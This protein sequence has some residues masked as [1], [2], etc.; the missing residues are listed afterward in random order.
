MDGWARKIPDLPLV[1]KYEWRKWGR[2]DG[3]TASHSHYGRTGEP[4]PH[5]LPSIA[6]RDAMLFPHSVGD[7]RHPFLSDSVGNI[8]E[9]FNGVNPT[10]M[11]P[12]IGRVF[13]LDNSNG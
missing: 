12:V 1:G 7:A 10:K 2:Y 3:Y 11:W 4:Y 8:R 13:G 9:N 6:A 5:R